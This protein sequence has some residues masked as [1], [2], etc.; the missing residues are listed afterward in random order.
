MKTDLL[1]ILCGDALET[2]NLINAANFYIAALS[3][4]TK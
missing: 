4:S 2:E 3:Q 1:T